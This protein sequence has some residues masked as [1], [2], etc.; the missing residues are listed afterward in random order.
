MGVKK[1]EIGMLDLVSSGA[2]FSFCLCNYLYCLMEGSLGGICCLLTSFN[3]LSIGLFSVNFLLLSNL[4][5][6]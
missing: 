3:C 4:I 5:L 6:N 2:K 1:K